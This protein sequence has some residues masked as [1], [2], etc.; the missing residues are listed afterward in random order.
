MRC[1]F[2]KKIQN[3]LAILFAFFCIFVWLITSVQ[4]AAYGDFD[5]YKREYEK[6]E[7]LSEL[8]MEM[9]DVMFVTTEM[10]DYLIGKRETLEV[11]T[12][13]DGAYQDFF[14]TQDRLHMED[15]KH[16]FL[17][18]LALRRGAFLLAILFLACIFLIKGD[19]QKILARGYLAGLG[20]TML[21]VI[22]LGIWVLLDFNQIFTIF[23][24][25]L[26]TNDLWLFDPA[27]DYMIR[28]L[29]EG[30]FADMAIRIGG[31]FILGLLLLCGVSIWS[32]KRGNKKN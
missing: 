28:M 32:I 3:I 31:I 8:D 30:F 4:I 22:I 21:G 13:V 19:V 26:F 10:M 29:P 6:Y 2:M 11:Y 24:E 5:F 23:H 14:N 7:V 17:S 9:E 1:R 16:L 18:G 15:V 12:H 27:T 25:I 20:I